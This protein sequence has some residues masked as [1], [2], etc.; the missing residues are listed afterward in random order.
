[1]EDRMEGS[2]VWAGRDSIHVSAR[3]EGLEL[4]RARGWTIS[5]GYLV[6]ASAHR[7]S[8]YL[9]PPTAMSDPPARHSTHNWQST[10]Y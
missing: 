8:A 10:F 6:A 2:K 5:S 3:E 1:M 4:R 7:D 9:R